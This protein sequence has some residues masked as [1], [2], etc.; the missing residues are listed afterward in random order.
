MGDTR[1]WIG[2]FTRKEFR[3]RMQ[4]GVIKA[5]IV[6]I[7]ST[8]QH[9]EHLH[10]CHDHIHC[11]KM[12][13]EIAKRM[14]PNVLVA[15]PVNTGV[16]EHHME[17]GPGTLTVRPEIFCEYVYDICESLVRTGIQNIL[18]LNGHGGNVKPMMY[19]FE[20]F[21][22]RLNTAYEKATS[23]RVMSDEPSFAAPG[24]DSQA[25]PINLRFQSYWDIYD[26]KLVFEH[27]EGGAAPGHACEFETSTM[28][29]LWPER[30]SIADIDPARP[31]ALA[32]PDK[33][34]ALWEPAILGNVKLLSQ[35]IRRVSVDVEPVTFLNG[36]RVNMMTGQEV[37]G[38]AKL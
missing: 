8:E 13:E 23:T 9:Q 3:E 1:V 25:G 38:A 10:M 4:A 17:V 7:S 28:L 6:P 24:H 36:S 2:D 31:E 26:P 21:Q 18:I 19:R 33:G 35:M 32:T 34:E 29:H 30:V 11:N 20:E 12:C 22:T 14:H 37:P 27:I 15:T 16:S 5:A